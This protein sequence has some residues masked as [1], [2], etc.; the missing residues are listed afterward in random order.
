MP[1]SATAS[2]YLLDN[3]WEHARRR[4]RLLERV[5][6]PGSTRRLDALGVGAGW[7]CLE[8]GAGGGSIT[9]WLCSRV[10]PTGRVLAVDLDTRFVDDI[11]AP[12]LDVAALDVTTTQ[13]PGGPFDLIH[14][15]AVLT[16]LSAR[17]DVLDRLIDSL[18]PRGWLLL[19]E[20]DAYPI[21]AIGPALHCEVVTKVLAGSAPSGLD[22]T[23][24]RDLPARLR[25]R[26]LDDIGAES[27]VPLAEGAS[28]GAEFLR[29]S[30][31]Q[32]HDL[33]VA[34]GVTPDQLDEWDALLTTPGRWFPGLAMVA[35]W[36]RRR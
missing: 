13:I 2:T 11:H 8:V 15:R 23:W 28:P 5:Y 30:T 4:L 21:E 29:L 20:P 17:E 12:N 6:D 26:G 24:G 33:A 35:A 3:A 19:E 32:L 25:S 10:G 7:R 1:V 22:A 34:A 27:E 31:L 36:G 16:H 9:R 18:A 14:A